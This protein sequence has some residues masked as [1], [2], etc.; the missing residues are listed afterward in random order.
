MEQPITT[1]TQKNVPL[2]FIG[3]EF[4]A[5]MQHQ[6]HALSITV[7]RCLQLH[8]FH[9]AIVLSPFRGVIGIDGLALAE[10]IGL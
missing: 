8:Q 5:T 3:R 6:W 10:A 2:T 4:I 9:P 7:A 1:S